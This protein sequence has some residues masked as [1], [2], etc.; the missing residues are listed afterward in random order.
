MNHDWYMVSWDTHISS[1]S[2]Y[3]STSQ[4]DICTGDHHASSFA[5]TT[6]LSRWLEASL[7]G[8]RSSS[9]KGENP[10]ALTSL[11]TGAGRHWQPPPGLPSTQPD[12][13]QKRYTAATLQP[14]TPER[15]PLAR[16]TT[17]GAKTTQDPTLFGGTPNPADEPGSTTATCPTCG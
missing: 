12:Q 15:S 9:T 3:A 10:D 11:D 6:A 13:D 14:P 2:P 17:T 4:S 16:S 7:A 8:F 5:S 1:S